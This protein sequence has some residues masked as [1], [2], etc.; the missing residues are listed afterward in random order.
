MNYLKSKNKNLQNI[1]I[2][3]VVLLNNYVL[4]LNN[5]NLYN[6]SLKM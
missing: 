5:E 4:C 6:V 1:S 3:Q 2:Y